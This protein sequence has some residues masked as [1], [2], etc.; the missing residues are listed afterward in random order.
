LLAEG[1]VLLAEGVVLLAE[2]VVL[3]AEGVVLLAEQMSRNYHKKYQ[4]IAKKLNY[5]NSY[6]YFF[7]L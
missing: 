5:T 7:F 3:L 6:F 4:K 1:V 2:G